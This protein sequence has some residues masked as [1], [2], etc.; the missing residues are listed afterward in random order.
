MFHR[1]SLFFIC[2]H[3]LSCS[4]NIEQKLDPNILYKRDMDITINGKY[5]N[6]VAVVPQA[7]KYEIKI[8]TVGRNDNFTFTTCHREESVKNQKNEVAFTFAPR[9]GLEDGDSCI[10]DMGGFDKDKGR[11]SWGILDFENPAYRV[12][13]TLDCNGQSLE[14]NGVGVCQS[15]AGLRQRIK[16]KYPVKV[17]PPIGCRMLTPVDELNFTFEIVKGK[18]VY[19]F[20]EPSFSRKY[21]LT[22]FGYEQILIRQD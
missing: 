15:L 2:F 10:A 11:H 3:L 14:T 8:R 22:T 12:Q 7:D 21:R 4:S 5:W 18:C 16:F 20:W 17:S 13:A 6:G 1:L 19:E 9:K